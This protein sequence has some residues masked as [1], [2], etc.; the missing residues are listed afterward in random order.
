M[1]YRPQPPS[2]NQI[3]STKTDRRMVADQTQ[4]AQDAFLPPFLFAVPSVWA[5]VGAMNATHLKRFRSSWIPE[6]AISKQAER[7]RTL[8]RERFFGLRLIPLSFLRV[9]ILLCT[10]PKVLRAVVTL[11]VLRLERERIV[12]LW[13][14]RAKFLRNFPPRLPF[15]CQRRRQFMQIYVRKNMGGPKI[16]IQ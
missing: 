1:R 16:S 13:E 9:Y 8:V 14:L 5:P 12:L 4:G 15:L 2:C 7:R 6:L 3:P 11:I 10:E